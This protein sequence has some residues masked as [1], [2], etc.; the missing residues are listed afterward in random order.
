MMTRW[1]A[2]IVADYGLTGEAVLADWNHPLELGDLPWEQSVQSDDY[3]G[4]SWAGILAKGNVQRSWTFTTRRQAATSVELYA[5]A[6]D[7]D[8][9]WTPG[10]NITLD[11]FLRDPDQPTAEGEDYKAMDYTRYTAAVA[12]I[13][14]VT[15]TVDPETM[16]VE[17]AFSVR[18]G[19]LVLHV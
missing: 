4:A 12:A 15:P 14:K 7:M 18:L 5:L 11:I 9:A 2:T 17:F 1:L 3:I 19:A 6:F 8:T 16:S 13:E 10:R